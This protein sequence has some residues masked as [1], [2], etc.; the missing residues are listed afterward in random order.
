MSNKVFEEKAL[1]VYL[2]CL[3]Y[4]KLNL[5]KEICRKYFREITLNSYSY[6]S[7]EDQYNMIPD[8]LN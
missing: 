1:R 6:L 2:K 7:W 5:A 4:R 8:N 3:H